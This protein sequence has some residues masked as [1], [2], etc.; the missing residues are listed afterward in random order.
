MTGCPGG[1]RG[2][3]TLRPE[4]PGSG[5]LEEGAELRVSRRKGFWGQTSQ[6]CQASLG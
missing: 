1:G 6:V 2:G 4:R 5:Q 3:W